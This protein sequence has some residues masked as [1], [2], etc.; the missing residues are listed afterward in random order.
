V[1]G[2]GVNNAVSRIGGL[3]G[4]AVVGIIMVHSFNS[5]L[6]RRLATMDLSP[7]VERS[8]DAKRDRLA[9]AEL[10]SHV[11]ERMRAELQ[12]AVDESFIFGFRLV[13]PAAAVLALAS[14]FVAWKMIENE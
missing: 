12:R 8:T 9:G 3:V 5:E 4:I 14:A 1:I 13:M 10:L 6:D 2:S 7:E 11:D